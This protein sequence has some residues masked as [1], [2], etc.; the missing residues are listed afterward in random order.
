[1]IPFTPEEVALLGTMSDAKVAEL[2]CTKANVKRFGDY[3]KRTESEVA[4]ERRE[5]GIPSFADSKFRQFNKRDLKRMNAAE[6]CE[7]FGY[8]EA[9]YYRFRRAAGLGRGAK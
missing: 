8:S 1:M 2:V 4:I 6:F 3:N 7:A 5:R 9:S